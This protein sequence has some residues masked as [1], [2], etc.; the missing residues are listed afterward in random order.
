[1]VCLY[2]WIE[3]LKCL[4]TKI[5]QLLKSKVVTLYNVGTLSLAL[6]N[7]SLGK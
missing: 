3:F 6:I 7:F 4:A 2:D 1:M 5:H